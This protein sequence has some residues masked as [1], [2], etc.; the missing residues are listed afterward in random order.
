MSK[1]LHSASGESCLSLLSLSPSRTPKC[2]VFCKSG[3]S[4]FS[5]SAH[6]PLMFTGCI[7][8]CHLPPA[9]HFSAYMQ[10]LAC[11]N[12]TNFYLFIEVLGLPWGSQPSRIHLQYRRG[13]WS[14]GWRRS[15]GGGAGNPLQYS[16]LKNPMDK[17]AWPAIVHGVGRSRTGRSH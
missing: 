16:C 8:S 4:C 12:N 7:I 17:E 15:A 14:L 6:G 11:C 3:G 10:L 5:L 13:V 1:R 2:V 9:P